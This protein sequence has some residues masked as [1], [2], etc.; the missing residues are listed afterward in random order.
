MYKLRRT[1][2]MYEVRCLKM[3][4]KE[5]LKKLDE[6]SGL[7]LSDWIEDDDS[8]YV[9]GILKGQQLIGCLSIGEVCDFEYVE[10][11]EIYE[12]G[13]LMLSDVYIKKDFRGNGLCQKMINFVLDFYKL[14]VD[15]V[16]LTIISENLSY[17]YEKCGFKLVD[18]DY[19]M[20][21][22]T[23]VLSLKA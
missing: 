18:E 11:L 3:S 22:S 9:W 12:Q 17:L 23:K 14:S 2:I 4:D 19:L 6:E 16:F 15:N 7:Q 8:D 5:D 21:H 10:K 13:D 1:F 20:V